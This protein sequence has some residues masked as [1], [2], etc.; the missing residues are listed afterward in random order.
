MDW[1][2]MGRTRAEWRLDGFGWG[3]GGGP[4]WGWSAAV[5]AAAGLDRVGQGRTIKLA[6]KNHGG[7]VGSSCVRICESSG[8]SGFSLW[9]GR[10]S[11]IRRTGRSTCPR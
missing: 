6:Y 5:M 2:Q 9:T 11:T 4:A 10:G 3:E 1:N 8:R 7:S